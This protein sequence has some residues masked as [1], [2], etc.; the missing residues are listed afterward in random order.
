MIYIFCHYPLI[1]RE[2]YAKLFTNW[3]TTTAQ[4]MK[5][6]LTLPVPIPD[7]KKKLS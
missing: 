5:K 4:K 6:S 2:S 7:E 3:S 1:S